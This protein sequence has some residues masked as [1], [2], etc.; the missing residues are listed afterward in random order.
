MEHFCEAMTRD[1][2]TDIREFSARQGVAAKAPDSSELPALNSP[3]TRKQKHPR[4]HSMKVLKLG[5]ERGCG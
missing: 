2:T 5:R 4:K 1:N 3:V